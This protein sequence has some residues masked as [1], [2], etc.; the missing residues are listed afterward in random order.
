MRVR[1]GVFVEMVDVGYAEVAGGEE[2]EGAGR[3]GGGGVRVEGEE[4]GAEEE[5][6]C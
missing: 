4:E 1:K 3:E 5:F 2:D 6:F